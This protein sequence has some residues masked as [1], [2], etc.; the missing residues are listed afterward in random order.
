MTI[1]LLTMGILRKMEIRGYNNIV[2]SHLG[3][4]KLRF[5]NKDLEEKNL[6]GIKET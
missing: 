2:L 1:H 6:F 5:E 4:F 3:F